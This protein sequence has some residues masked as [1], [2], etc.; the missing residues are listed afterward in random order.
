MA[1][2]NI[3]FL[4]AILLGLALGSFCGSASYRIAH[5]W[6]LFKPS[7][8]H[9]PNCKKRLSWKENIPLLSF[10]LQR[11]RCRN[12]S[13][14]LS[15]L[16]PIAELTFACWS[17]LIFLQYG[18]SAEYFVFMG[19]GLILLLISLVDLEAYFI[20]DLLV[21]IGVLIALG[22]SL[23]GIGMPILDALLGA[24]VGASLLQALRLGYQF[25]RKQEG[26]GFGDVKLMF[27]LGLCCGI[28][29]LP[30]VLLFAA[31]LALVFTMAVHRRN[32]HSQTRLPFG[33]YLCAG[34]AIYMLFGHNILNFFTF[35]G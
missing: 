16:Y 23:M 11:G 32:T 14:K 9:C 7:G 29:G 12:C 15:L 22:A 5:E 25:L 20:P 10:I 33:P 24:I 17:I 28:I 27:L 34:C 13:A 31:L 18:M 26:M 1:E 3:F 8:S 2:Y 6:S 4:I 19:I 35:T 21:L 30:Y